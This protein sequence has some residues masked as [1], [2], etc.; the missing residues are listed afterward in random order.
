MYVFI[1]FLAKEKTALEIII[2]I[3]IIII[4]LALNMHLLKHRYIH[5]EESGL[6]R[7]YIL[8]L[9]VSLA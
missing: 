3:I 9:V 1:K 5:V 2:I 8:G 7:I 6:R 4:I